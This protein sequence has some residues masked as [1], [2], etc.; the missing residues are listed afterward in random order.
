[1]NNYYNNQ[2]YQ[3]PY[4]RNNYGMPNYMQPQQQMQQFD[5]PIQYVG[6]ANLKE[7][8][9]HIIMPNSK[10]IFIDKGNGVIYEKVCDYNDQSFIK[11]YKQVVNE[12]ENKAVEPRNDSASIDLSTYATKDELCGYVSLKQYNELLSKVEDLKKM[13]GGKPNV[14]TIKQQ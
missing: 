1:M 12:S 14:G 6:Y 13:I 3:N 9:A 2:N 11:E 4:A 10:A 5:M 8:E 7:T